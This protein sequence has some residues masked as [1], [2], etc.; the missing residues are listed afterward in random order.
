MVGGMHVMTPVLD[1]V[2]LALLGA[3]LWRLRRDPGAA[4]RAHERKLHQTVEGLRALVAEAEQHARALDAGLA[5]HAR[6]LR[7][8][9]A[10]ARPGSPAADVTDGTVAARVRSLAAKGAS[11][12]DIARRLGVPPAEVRLMVGLQAVRAAARGESGKNGAADS[13]A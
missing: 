3:V 10:T 11:V 6:E 5:A 13:A 4:W 7:G 2:L 1:L 12:E 9:L 8:L